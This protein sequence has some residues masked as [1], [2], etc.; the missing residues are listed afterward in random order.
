MTEMNF[1]YIL[2]CSDGTYYT[3]WTN[4]LDKRIASHNDGS[5][6]KYTRVRRPV[7]LVYAEA[8]GTK[9]EAMRRE[10]EIKKMRRGDK[11]KLIDAAERSSGNQN[12]FPSFS[13]SSR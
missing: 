10:W 6:S 8:F 3:G 7:E 1:T 4:D 9:Q 5:G 2:R 13:N 11:Q 12:S